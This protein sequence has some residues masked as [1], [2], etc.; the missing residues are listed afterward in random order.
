MYDFPIGVILES[1]KLGRSEAIRKASE[2]GAKGIQMYATEGQ[3]SPENLTKADRIELRREVETND[4]IFSALCG[5]LGRGFG[6]K[7]LN[8]KLIE[9]SKRIVEL[10]KDLGTDIVT[11]H[12]GV[13]PSDKNHERYKIMQ[14][15]CFAL[16]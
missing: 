13:I 3:N 8:P 14:E 16:C 12:I 10:A 4:L 15:A 2:I 11:T 1:F 7:E 6:N 9:K 5:D